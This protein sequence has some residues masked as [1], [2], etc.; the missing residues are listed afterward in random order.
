MN[1]SIRRAL[2]PAAVMTLCLGLAPQVFAQ[3]TGSP[4]YAVT[5]LASDGFV[6]A[7]HIDPQLIN[8]W[9]IAFNPYGFVWVADAD[10]GVS[11]LYDGNGAKQSLVVNI[12]TPTANTGGNGIGIVYNGSTGFVVTQSAVSGASRFIFSTEQGLIAGWAPNVDGTHAIV[13]ANRSSAGASYRGLALSA[14]GG[15]QVLY[16]SD[17][18]NAR[19]DAFDANFAL[20]NLGANAFKD[21][22]LPHGYAPFGI[23]AINGDIFVTYALQ[24]ADAEEEVTGAGLGFV[25]VFTPNGKFIRRIASRDGLNAPWGLA[26]APAAFG[27]Q[28]G[29]LLVGNFGD[30]HINTFDVRTGRR[31]GSLND[32]NGMPLAIN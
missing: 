17:F 23:Q 32:A 8:P 5:S 11:T 19:V 1:G 21:P 15:G 14:N 27:F 22:T 18:H 2:L 30:G 28:H 6:S 25:S 13:A 3:T 31:L 10:A 9:G 20:L 12:P 7:A 26:E 24:D 16:A 4:R 29:V